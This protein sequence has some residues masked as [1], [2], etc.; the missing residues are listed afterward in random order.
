VIKVI[1]KNKDGWSAV[2]NFPGKGGGSL[3]CLKYQAF[4]CEILSHNTFRNLS[5]RNFLRAKAKMKTKFYARKTMQSN[6]TLERN[7]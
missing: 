4:P 6:K 1:S 2:G 7:C 5:L 3:G